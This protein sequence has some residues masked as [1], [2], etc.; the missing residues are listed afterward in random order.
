MCM[1]PPLPF[2]QPDAL[3]NGEQKITLSDRSKIPGRWSENWNLG[4]KSQYMKILVQ[5]IFIASVKLM[6]DTTICLKFKR[7]T[8]IDEEY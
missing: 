1:E 7:C 8:S 5:V 2:A 4:Y 3:P 6:E